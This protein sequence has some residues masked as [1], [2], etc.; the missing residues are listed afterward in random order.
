MCACKL[1][2]ELVKEIRESS[3]SCIALAREYGVSESTI[4]S[5]KNGQSWGL[6]KNEK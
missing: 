5:V 6:V 1:T 4:R 2:P 3:L